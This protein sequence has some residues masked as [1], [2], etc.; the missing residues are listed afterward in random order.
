M[1]N[2]VWDESE[3]KRMELGDERPWN[4]V[5]PKAQGLSGGPP[6]WVQGPRLS[7]TH[8][9]S[10]KIPVGVC[11]RGENRLGPRTCLVGGQEV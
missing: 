9:D 2:R 8:A 4:F 6:G 10:Q 5:Q 1:D 7:V 11:E 3:E